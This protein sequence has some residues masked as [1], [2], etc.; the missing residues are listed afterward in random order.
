MIET[1]ELW[2]PDRRLLSPLGMTRRH[3]GRIGM[4]RGDACDCKICLGCSR[5]T[6]IHRDDFVVDFQVNLTIADDVCVAGQSGDTCYVNVTD[7]WSAA[8][9]SYISS[10]PEV[11]WQTC[12][13]LSTDDYD[14]TDS[15]YALQ[16]TVKFT[17]SGWTND[18]TVELLVT[19]SCA[20][21]PA[22]GSV[23]MLSPMYAKYTKSFG[24]GPISSPGEAWAVDT[25]S[26]YGVMTLDLDSH[27]GS[28]ATYYTPNTITM[29][30]A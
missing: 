26:T 13:E 22:C 16:V 21:D 11:I 3:V 15:H 8:Y 7:S 12:H 28:G 2:V 29:E 19:R 30:L 9:Y 10:T 1:P 20:D 25:D 6:H 4:G 18:W 27:S 17:C 24:S 5:S 23:V 14:C